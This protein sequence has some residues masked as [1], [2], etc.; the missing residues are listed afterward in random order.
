[1]AVS[2]ATRS[3]RNLPEQSAA[4]R[5]RLIV[6]ES[7]GRG[8]RVPALPEWKQISSLG[9]VLSRE[10]ISTETEQAK[11]PERE[12]GGG[13]EPTAEQVYLCLTEKKKQ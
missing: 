4:S 7:S 11:N 1:M 8:G 6:C 10:S 9:L 2:E 5:C 3:G 12:E 13:L